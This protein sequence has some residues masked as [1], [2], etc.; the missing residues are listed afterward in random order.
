MNPA[1]I[2]A[3]LA[4]LAGAT[5]TA[6]GIAEEIKATASAD[7]QAKIDA[8]IETARG[9]ATADAAQA[10]ADLDAAAAT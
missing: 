9:R 1:T 8:A 3:L 10:E 2:I 5:Q 6:I 7:D 4:N